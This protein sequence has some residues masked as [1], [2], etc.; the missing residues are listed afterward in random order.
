MKTKKNQTNNQKTSKTQ[1]KS[2]K[3]TKKTGEI[4]KTMK[5]ASATPR[6]LWPRHFEQKEFGKINF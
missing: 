4:L 5:K 3:L 6:G 2:K 1:T